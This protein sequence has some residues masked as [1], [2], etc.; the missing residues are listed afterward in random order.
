MHQKPQ[1]RAVNL[2]GN[3]GTFYVDFKKRKVNPPLNLTIYKG[4]FAVSLSRQFVN[5]VCQ[6]K[7]A[8]DY[9]EWLEDT[10][11]PDEQFWATLIYNKGASSTNGSFLF[12]W[13][14]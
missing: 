1:G 7:T 13:I 5:F 14:Q 3:G 2:L 8:V 12:F 9:L 6:N 11:I 4:S 10:I